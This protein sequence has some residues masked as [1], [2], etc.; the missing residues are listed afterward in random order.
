MCQINIQNSRVHCIFVKVNH[1]VSVG[2]GLVLYKNNDLLDS[3]LILLY[4]PFEAAVAS[5][6]K[7]EGVV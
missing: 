2:Q 4:V 5:Y 3:L 6:G 7:V 1:L